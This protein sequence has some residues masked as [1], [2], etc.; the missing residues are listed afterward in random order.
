MRYGSV[1]FLLL[2]PRLIHHKCLILN[3]P[4]ALMM[5]ARVFLMFTRGRA[6]VLSLFLLH[7]ILFHLSLSF[8]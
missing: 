1:D 2:K 4:R 3:S 5:R 7:A 6:G 8:C